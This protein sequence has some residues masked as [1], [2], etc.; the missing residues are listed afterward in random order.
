MTTEVFGHRLNYFRALLD[1]CLAAAQHV[2]D[3]LEE[4]GVSVEVVFQ[5]ERMKV[6]LARIDLLLN[7]WVD[8]GRHSR[9]AHLM[10]ELIRSTQ[11]RRSIAH[12]AGSSFAQLARKVVER[13]A[14]TGEHYITRD[15]KE[16]GE[17]LRAAAGGGAGH[18]GH[19]LPEVPDL[20]PAPGQSSWRACWPSL[21]YAGS[22]LRDPFRAF[23][24]GDQAAGDDRPGA[25]RPA[26]RRG[27]ARARGIRRRHH[28]DDPL[29][30]GGDFR[31][32]G[33]GVS[34]WRCWCSGWPTN[35]ARRQPDPPAKA[36]AT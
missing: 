28:R 33:R 2:Y 7:A 24:A 1:G 12:L 31:Q 15:R 36:I 9:H 10:A 22:F 35:A 21:N 29:E 16:Y 18:G 17:L 27:A 23:H 25:G 20:W 14:E 5:I 30:G 6:R 13:S 26:R 3:D 19:G 32:P 34:R 8:P 4:N 11:A